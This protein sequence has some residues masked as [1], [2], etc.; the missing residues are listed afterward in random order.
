MKIQRGYKT[1]LKL[2]NRQKTNCLKHCGTARFAWNWGFSRKK[3]AYK[4]QQ[5]TLTAIDLHR[6]LNKLKKSDYC[7]MYDVSKCAPQESLRDLDRAYNNFFKKINRFPRYKKKKHGVGSFRLTGTIKV[8]SG[9]IQLPRLGKLKLKEKDYLPT[10]KHILSATVS[11]DGSCW[12]ISIQVKEDIEIPKNNGEVVGVD[13]GINPLAYI[14]DGTKIENPKVFKKYEKKIGRL[15][16][17]LS[18]K[19]KGSENW[20]KALKEIQNVYRRIKNTRKDFIHKIT[21]NLA[22]T[23]S[24]VVL[25]DL[26]VSGMM[27]NHY[28]A[29]SI[30][31]VGMSEFRSQIVYKTQW[32]GSQLLLADRYYPSSKRCSNCGYI[33]SEMPLSKRVFVC[34]NCNFTLDRDFNAS[35]NLEMAVSSPDILKTPN[36]DDCST[37]FV[38]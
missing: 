23:K 5:K 12:F 35:L 8:F 32:Y 31:D 34:E 24:V 19:K 27:K 21:T 4:E 14:S 11:E 33:N 15:Q 1:E 2:N 37:Q 3:E 36:G 18:K 7:W 20:K 13:L 10:D 9:Y 26:N 38:Q 29:K 25:E 22:K 16:R 28:L 30:S 17:Q 6:E